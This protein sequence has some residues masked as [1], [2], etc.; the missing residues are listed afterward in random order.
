MDDS[1][2]DGK[3][4]PVRTRWSAFTMVELLVVVAIIALLASLLLGAIQIVRDLAKS[5]ACAS[6]M[7][8]IGVAFE[9]FAADHQG[10]YPPAMLRGDN[11]GWLGSWSTMTEVVGKSGW[12]SNWNT[13]F[14]YLTEYTT[15][16]NAKD[17][18]GNVQAIRKVWQCPTHPRRIAQDE[19][20]TWG[21]M[22]HL[23]SNSEIGIS[24]GINTAY[25]G[26]LSGAS[27]YNGGGIY[28]AGRDGW[29]G[30]AVGIDNMRDNSR[31][32]DRFRKAS[33]T[34]QMAE[35]LGQPQ[36][37]LENRTNWTSPPFARPPVDVTGAPVAV[38]AGFGSWSSG[39]P[40]SDNLLGFSLRIAHRGRSNYLFVDG[41][42]ESLTPWETCSSDPSQDNLWTGR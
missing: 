30:Y 19:Q 28:P 8:Q 6:N 21:A 10:Y 3:M 22:A 42:V 23:Y 24:Y 32:R 33:R 25:L 26:A 2:K 14:A 12:G 18:W 5:T 41:R 9:T 31:V 20:G 35:H 15:S 27:A 4:S 1:G 38:P 40:I 36:I 34:I 13:W 7:R 37:T 39:F 17:K 16:D 29:P 11:M